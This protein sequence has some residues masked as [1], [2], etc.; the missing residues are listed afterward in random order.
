MTSLED[1]QSS[2][3]TAIEDAR[4]AKEERGWLA[5]FP[6]PEF[7]N[8][9][10][11]VDV[12]TLDQ[13]AANFSQY[14]DIV[15]DFNGVY[16][17]EIESKLGKSFSYFGV[18]LPGKLQNIGSCWDG[19]KV[20]KV[21]EMDNLYVIKSDKVTV[22]KHDDE[23]G[24]YLIHLEQD[25]AKFE[26]TPREFRDQ[27]AEL[28]CELISQEK[29]PGC[30][31]HGGYNS[32][33]NER[34]SADTC[35]VNNS[36]GEQSDRIERLCSSD[37]GY[38]GVRYNGPAVTSQFIAHGKFLLTWDVTPVFLF[39]ETNSDIGNEVWKVLQVIRGKN[40]NK[41]F[42]YGGIHLVPDM[43]ENL[44]RLSTARMEADTLRDLQQDAALKK[45]FS[46]SKVLASLI[47][48]WDETNN[49]NRLCYSNNPG[50]NIV[51]QL[52]KY[53]EMV[54]GVEKTTAKESLNK[55]MRYAHM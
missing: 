52:D 43:T 41:M 7:T 33:G 46:L 30:L 42:S 53:L 21:N 54:D 10:R 1:I 38:S 27:F 44:W 47:K 34:S 9:A 29:L 37:I 14:E 39:P 11:K 3:Y 20:G 2:Y 26:I 40:P 55:L 19:S 24:C 25:T 48:D 32:C 35:N 22:R 36:S 13:E 5:A 8:W 6:I 49:T 4:V 17:S 50:V 23:P 18:F 16:R 45:A 12:F 31:R 51:M 28:L 15:K